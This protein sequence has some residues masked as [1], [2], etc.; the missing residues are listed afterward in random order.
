M[1]G[2]KVSKNNELNG[3]VNLPELRSLC[4]FCR[5]RISE[6]W[7]LVAL[8]FVGWLAG[9][10]LWARRSL[11]SA[12]FLFVSAAVLR[13][14]LVLVLG[15]EFGRFV[16]ISNILCL[17]I[18]ISAPAPAAAASVTATLP[19][20]FEQL[21][22]YAFT[23]QFLGSIKRIGCQLIARYRTMSIRFINLNGNLRPVPGEIER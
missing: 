3:E 5:R 19:F 13:A 1:F 10:S 15:F 20:A 7:Q 14:N 2:E 21:K 17:I 6:S 23:F 22:F 9:C 8:A 16:V 11:S 18:S 12:S 4:G